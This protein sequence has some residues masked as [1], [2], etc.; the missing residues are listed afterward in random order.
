VRHSARRELPCRVRDRKSDTNEPFNKANAKTHKRGNDEQQQ[1][2]LTSN[3]R[4]K[5]CDPSHSGIDKAGYI[6]EN[7]G[8]RQTSL[9]A[10]KTLNQ[11]NTQTDK[12]HDD[13]SQNEGVGS[14]SA[15][16]RADPL[17]GFGNKCGDVTNNSS[18]GDSSR[19]LK[20]HPFFKKNYEIRIISRITRIT[21]IRKAKPTK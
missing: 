20:E 15:D 8:H 3:S 17:D 2:R 10:D 1:K 21:T 13:E 7:S 16:E 19:F 11:T 5:A 4:A 14:D 12:G 6:G 18:D 9:H